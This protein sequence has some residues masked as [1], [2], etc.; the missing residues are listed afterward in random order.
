VIHSDVALYQ[1]CIAR[2]GKISDKDAQVAAEV[3]CVKSG[4]WST[5]ITQSTN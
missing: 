5:I 2:R 4:S 3:V 1:V